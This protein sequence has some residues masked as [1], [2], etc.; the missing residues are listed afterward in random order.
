M[1]IDFTQEQKTKCPFKKTL[2][3]VSHYLL[4][5]IICFPLLL[6]KFMTRILGAP[7]VRK[8]NYTKEAKHL[9]SCAKVANRHFL[10]IFDE[11]YNYNIIIQLLVLNRLGQCSTSFV[12]GQKYPARKPSWIHVTWEIQVD[13]G[14]FTQISIDFLAR[15]LLQSMSHGC[16]SWISQLDFP[17]DMDLSRNLTKKST[18]IHTNPPGSSSIQLEI[19]LDFLAGYF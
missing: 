12:P 15:F 19:Q 11:L 7:L 13:Q 2:R 17:C 5:E 14:G 9:I 18:E 16:P 6:R 4:K 1:A 3:H 8:I 10:T